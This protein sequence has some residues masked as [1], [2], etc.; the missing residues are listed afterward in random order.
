[1][2]IVSSMAEIRESSKD[3]PPLA[4]TIGNFDGVHRGHQAMLRHLKD[5]ARNNGQVL[6][7]LTFTPHPRKVLRAPQEGFLLCSESQRR[8]WLSEAGVE[9][10]VEIP[11][12]RDL[13]T[14][15]AGDFLDQHVLTYPQLRSIHLG[16][17]FAFGANKHAGLQEVRAHCADLGIEV[18]ECPRFEVDN[19]PI[20]S[21]AIRSRLALGKVEEAN[22]LLGRPFAL[23]GLVVK[24]EGRGRRIGVPTANLQLAAD[25]MLP[26]IGVYVTETLSRGMIHRSVTN[27]GRNPTFKE[28]GPAVVETHLLDFDGDLYGEVL[29]VRFLKFLRTE[30]KFPSVDALLE[31]IHKD[32]ETS[33]AYPAV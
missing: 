23:E 8:H 21:S 25:L 28:G 7:V 12:T 13:S 15:E 32:I 16:W 24:G 17:D 33:R 4:L 19:V 1:M 31:Q 29:E 22:L 3:H 5:L 6:A 14:L 30:K 20:S 9:W 18:G 10:L 27:V 26:G 2:K 11:F